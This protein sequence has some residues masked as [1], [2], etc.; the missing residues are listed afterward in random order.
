[1]RRIVRPLVGLAFLL[2][3]FYGISL[4]FRAVDG[5]REDNARKQLKVVA[6]DRDIYY[7][8]YSAMPKEKKDTVFLAEMAKAFPTV[9]TKALAAKLGIEVQKEEAAKKEGE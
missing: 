6:Q 1:M 9:E 3:F 8:A 2:A 7:A 5:D 4:C